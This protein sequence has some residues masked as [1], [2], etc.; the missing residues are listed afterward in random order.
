[1]NESPK[2]VR[3]CSPIYGTLKLWRVARFHKFPPNFSELQR[4]SLPPSVVTWAFSWCTSAALSSNNSSPGRTKRELMVGCAAESQNWMENLS[5][6]KQ[7]SR[8]QG[9]KKYPLVMADV[10]IE[11]DHRNSGYFPMKNG[12]SFHSWCDPCCEKFHMLQPS[13][14]QM[15]T[16]WHLV[17]HLQLPT[18]TFLDLEF[19]L[20]AMDPCDVCD[21]SCCCRL[22]TTLSSNRTYITN[23]FEIVWM[24]SNS[25][26]HP[27][28]R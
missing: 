12:G 5:K 2:G 28:L 18:G 8:H 27:S 7:R 16:P 9:T 10:A 23:N 20:C 22:I 17:A 19:H 25:W 21:I 6:S 26:T 1:M 24:I 13:N 15:L 3:F 14:H 11:N 4:T